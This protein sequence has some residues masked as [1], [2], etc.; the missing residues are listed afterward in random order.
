MT[1]YSDKHDIY[2]DHDDDSDVSEIDMAKIRLIMKLRGSVDAAVISAIERV[3]RD[4]FVDEVFAD[5]SYQDLALPISGG[6]T[7]SQPSVVARM[8]DALQL[9]YR[10]K[11]LEVG[12]GSGYQAAILSYLCRRVYTVERRPELTRLARARFERMGLH[13]ITAKIGDGSFGWEEQAPFDRIIVTAA[14][15]DV[16][17]ALVDQLKHEG[18]MIIPVGDDI[19]GQMV[20]RIEKESSGKI[21]YKELFPVRFVHLLPGI[22]GE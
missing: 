11:V 22:S 15:E 19:S 13:A 12:T 18:I 21:N 14:A 7:I 8:T 10:C 1:I 2:E 5:K 3:S 16:P 20:L 4:E 6:Q 9:D 17:M